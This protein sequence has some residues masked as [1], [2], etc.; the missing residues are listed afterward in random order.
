MSCETSHL[1]YYIKT[2]EYGEW[3]NRGGTGIASALVQRCATLVVINSPKSIGARHT[4]AQLGAV[5]NSLAELLQL[6]A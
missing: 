2:H 5:G 4:S 1:G 3:K 6:S